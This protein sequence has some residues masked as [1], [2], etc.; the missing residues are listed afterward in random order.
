LDFQDEFDTKFNFLSEKRRGRRRYSLVSFFEISR[1]LPHV[2]CIAKNVH[3]S[4]IYYFSLKDSIVEQPQAVATD[5]CGGALLCWRRAVREKKRG[6]TI[7]KIKIN[8]IFLLFQIIF[9]FN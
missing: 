7:I 1:K 6:K 5:L 2:I 8:F 9:F 3:L 4:L